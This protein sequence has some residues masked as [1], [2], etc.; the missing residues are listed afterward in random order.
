MLVWRGGAKMLATLKCWETRPDWRVRAK[1]QGS[2]ESGPSRQAESNYQGARQGQ[3]QAA[4]W[5][6]RLARG[7]CRP[8]DSSE[9]WMPSSGRNI[10]PPVGDFSIVIREKGAWNHGRSRRIESA[11]ALEYPPTVQRA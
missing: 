4:S 11:A 5:T 2:F 1:M 10:Q 7:G 9:G 8:R 6:A 3:W